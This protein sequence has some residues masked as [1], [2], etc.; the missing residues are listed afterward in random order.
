MVSETVVSMVSETVVS[1]VVS[2]TVV[3]TVVSETVVS[4]VSEMLSPVGTRRM[5]SG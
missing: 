1:T 2:E 3:S 4:M 5:M